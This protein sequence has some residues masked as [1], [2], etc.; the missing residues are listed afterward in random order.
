[1]L[2]LFYLLFLSCDKF[3]FVYMLIFLSDIKGDLHDQGF[4]AVYFLAFVSAGNFL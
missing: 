3:V 4:K 2:L 1:M